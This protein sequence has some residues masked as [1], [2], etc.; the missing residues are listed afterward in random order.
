MANAQNEVRGPLFTS[1]AGLTIVVA[2]GL[3]A[4][5]A[6][7]RAVGV[8]HHTGQAVILWVMATALVVGSLLWR[9]EVTVSASGFSL[10]SFGRE[11]WIPWTNVQRIDGRNFGAKFI[12]EQPQLIGRN[13]KST[14]T[15]AQWDP[16][17]RKRPTVLA[18]LAGLA[19][20]QQGTEP[21][22]E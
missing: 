5:M 3:G 9:T 15:F 12:F 6:A 19:V 21:P 10:N 16:K 8:V 1:I 2:I 4:V 7:M 14:F 13:P 11:V 22:E 20:S 18:A 17:W